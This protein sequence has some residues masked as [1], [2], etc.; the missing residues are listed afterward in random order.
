MKYIYD[1]QEVLKYYNDI[2]ELIVR[3][4]GDFPVSLIQRVDLESY[5]NKIFQ[6]G[7]TIIAVNDSQVVG[8]MLFYSNNLGTKTGYIT[9]LC[10]DRTCRKN[11]IA[12]SL[13]KKTY[14][15]MKKD[16]M[17]Y[18][19]LSTNENN[20]RSIQLYTKQGFKILENRE[21]ELHMK[22]DLSELNILLTSVGRRSYL[23]EYF[24]QC[25]KG[26]GKVY[27]SN[28]DSLSP[29]F[30]VADGYVKTPLIYDNNYIDF[31]LSYC[32]EKNISMIVS[33]FDIDLPILSKN[34]KKFD[35]IG[36]KV[37]VSD[38]RVI[39]ICN[40]K[41]NTYCFLVENDIKTPKSYID[42]SALKEDLKKKICKF[43]LVVKP[44]WGM[45]SIGIFI[46]DDEE[47]LNVFY[48]KTKKAIS[49]SYLK[50][51]SN[52]DLEHCVIVQEMIQGQEYGMDIINDLN[53]NYQS[54]IVRKKIAMRSGETDTAQIVANCFVENIAKK[55]SNQLRHV[56]NLDVDFFVDQNQEIYVLEMNA[57]FGGGYPFSH[58]SGVNLPKALI[59]WATGEKI[60]REILEVKKEIIGQKDIQI[61]DITEL[62]KI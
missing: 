38:E 55:I 18:C 42:M 24:K 23:V 28:S 49:S 25:L 17:N 56:A 1:K 47:E 27:V 51:E 2:K 8:C 4:D 22:K 46:A 7:K 39:N 53:G 36:V 16:G 30:L 43:P 40:D 48:R 58:L 62:N 14:S 3:N 15:I 37:I 10:V 44:R 19:E 34:K 9:L 11:G 52:V 21:G 12:S 57:R 6:F 26:I 35:E 29:A 61:V 50:Y 59:S 33:L 54:S 31:L 32:K 13:L 41:W 45:G 20:N 60:E 5:L